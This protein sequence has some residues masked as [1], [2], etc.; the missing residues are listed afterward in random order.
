MLFVGLACGRVR[1]EVHAGGLI[2]RAVSGPANFGS[3]GCRDKRPWS[4][5]RQPFRERVR[6]ATD[7]QQGDTKVQW[8][9]RAG[10]SLLS[11]AVASGRELTR[12]VR[13][14]SESAYAHDC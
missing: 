6:P 3:N 12:L 11:Q 4:S 7:R 9:T 8:T 10:G 2:V 5:A 13:S 1:A 14:Q